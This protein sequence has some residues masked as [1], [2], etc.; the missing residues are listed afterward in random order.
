M[1]TYEG[2][3]GLGALG[4][5]SKTSVHDADSA[6]GS[7][8]TFQTSGNGN[9][10]TECSMSLSSFGRAGIG[11]LLGATS[12]ARFIRPYMQA[13]EKEI[14]ALDPGARIASR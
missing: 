8:V 10:R 4:T 13:V 1:A 12:D 6:I 11:G 9:G 5:M 3:K 14:R 2:R 7:E